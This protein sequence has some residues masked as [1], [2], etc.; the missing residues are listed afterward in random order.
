MSR[1]FGLRDMSKVVSVC[2]GR[3]V[4]RPNPVYGAVATLKI[5]GLKSPD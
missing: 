1:D 4:Y 3:H 5:A 2:L